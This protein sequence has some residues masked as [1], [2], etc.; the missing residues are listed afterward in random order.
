MLIMVNL[1]FFIDLWFLIV[2]DVFFGDIVGGLWRMI[3]KFV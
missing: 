2:E 3:F 1:Y